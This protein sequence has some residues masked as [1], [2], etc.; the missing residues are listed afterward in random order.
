[1]P[2]TA[3][4]TVRLPAQVL[5]RLER[6]AKATDRTKA[7]LAGRAIEEYVGTQEWQVQEIQA[8]VREADS[9]TAQ[10]IEHAAVVKRIR[11]KL[12]TRKRK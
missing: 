10:F 3:T 7:Y 9:D 11:S 4:M 2:Q 6:I 8:A 12:T 5:T 1:M